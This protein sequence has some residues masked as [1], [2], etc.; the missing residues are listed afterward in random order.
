[1]LKQVL[2]HA[3][4]MGHKIIEIL[5][6]NY[7]ELENKEIKVIIREEGITQSLTVAFAPQQNLSNEREDRT[8]SKMSSVSKYSIY[9]ICYIKSSI[10]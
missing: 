2:T 6:D 3:E 9:N 7:E 10:A 8:V 5:S 1:M 4:T